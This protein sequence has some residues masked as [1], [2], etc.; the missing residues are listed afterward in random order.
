VQ[1]ISKKR[2]LS[3]LLLDN[4]FKFLFESIVDIMRICQIMV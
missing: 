1:Q 4:C 3:K 2:D